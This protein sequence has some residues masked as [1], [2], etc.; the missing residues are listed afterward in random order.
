MSATPTSKTVYATTRSG[1]WTNT[2]AMCAERRAIAAA[3]RQLEKGG[4]EGHGL[5]SVPSHRHH[6]D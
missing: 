3:K 2:H 4:Q 5:E 1:T 6:V